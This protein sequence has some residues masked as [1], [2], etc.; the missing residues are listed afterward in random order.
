MKKALPLLTAAVLF[1]GTV[2][3]TRLFLDGSVRAMGE[4]LVYINNDSRNF[5]FQAMEDRKSTR[6]NSSHM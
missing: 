6:L 1:A 5:C 2:L 3:G 4:T